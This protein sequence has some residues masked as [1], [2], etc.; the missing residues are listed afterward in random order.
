MSKKLGISINGGGMLGV[1]PLQFMCRMESDLG[2]KLCDVSFAYGGTSTGSIIAAGLA[3][4]KSAQELMDLYKGNLKKIFDKYSWYKRLQPKCPTYDN[5][6][7]K[8]ILK[9]EFIGI[10]RDARSALRGKFG[11]YIRDWEKPIYIPTTHMNGK[12]VEKVWDLGD[13]D[14]EKWFAI[15]TSCAAPTYFDVIMDGKNSYCDGG[16]WA[17]DP[18]MVLE[19]GLKNAGHDNF[20]ILQFNTGM[21]TPNTDSG[22]KTLVGWAEYIFDEW[23][24]RS[25]MS[26]YYECCANIGKENVFRAS[27]SHPSK[28]KMDKVDDKTVQ[29]VIEIW[30][31]YYDSVRKEL[32]EFMK[33]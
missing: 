8:K 28:I 2:K 5:S 19:S 9:R 25:G 1:G 30:D 12:S 26:N 16:M 17:N 13:K 18:I 24:A 3:E 22:N 15:L 29:E 32:L 23:V 33:R 21:D 31:K 20:K 4:G 7:L 10:I 6:N 14:V 11:G 27:P